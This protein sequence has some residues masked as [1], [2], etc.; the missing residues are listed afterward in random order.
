MSGRRVAGID[1]V[2]SGATGPAA[3][4]GAFGVVWG[5]HPV[6]RPLICKGP[7]CAR[8]HPI[9]RMNTHCADLHCAWDLRAA[10]ERVP[11]SC[12]RLPVSECVPCFAQQPMRLTGA[13]AVACCCICPNSTSAACLWLCVCC[14]AAHHGC[15]ASAHAGG[16]SSC[17]F[18][19]LFLC[20]AGA[21]QHHAGYSRT[22]R[23]GSFQSSVVR[24]CTLHLQGMGPLAALTHGAT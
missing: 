12:L 10:W 9:Q 19:F 24:V 2:H 23:A 21:L 1:V 18:T 15:S 13:N 3:G 16:W 22:P 8:A 4:G 6:L 17:A 11:V 5:L 14:C 20:K 7:L